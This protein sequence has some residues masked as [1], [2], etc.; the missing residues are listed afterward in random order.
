MRNARGNIEEVGPNNNPLLGARVLA[1]LNF[2]PHIAEYFHTPALEE[3]Q[4]TRSSGMRRIE[5]DLLG[6]RA[7]PGEV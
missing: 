1:S 3:A 2:D 4:M 5:H 6:E 7:I